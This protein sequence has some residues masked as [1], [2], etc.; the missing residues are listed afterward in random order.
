M[1]ISQ[2]AA[3]SG[4]PASTLRFISAVKHLGLPLEEI[5]DLLGD[6][7]SGSCA[8]VKADLRPRV[9]A[10]LE[11]ATQRASELGAFTAT[12]RGAIEYLDALPD[13]AGP[14]DPGCGF[15][16]REK[17][18]SRPAGWLPSPDRAPQAARAPRVSGGARH[19]WH[20][21]FLRTT[22]PTGPRLGARPS[23]ARRRSASRT[24]C[25]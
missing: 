24:G 19:R 23:A 9:A 25:G 21:P 6:W 10:R 11:Q 22:S 16:T 17:Q 2:L 4:V 3:R 5:R 15:L 1:R 18:P 14:C 13:W 12:L 20:A 8:Q 7:E